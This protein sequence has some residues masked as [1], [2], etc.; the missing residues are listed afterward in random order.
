[1]T[2]PTTP[3]FA[4]INVESQHANIRSE[5][6]SGRTQTRSIGAQ[7][8]KFTAKYNDLTRAEFAPV[9]A[10]I[11]S[12]GSGT[13]AFNITPP[14]ISN[15]R[16]S[17]SGTVTTAAASIGASSVSVSGFSGNIKAGDF[18]KFSNHS[19]VYMATADAN[20]GAALAIAP[21]LL[22]A[23]TS[24]TTVSYN[25]VTFNMRTAKDVQKFGL[26]EFDK[27]TYE[28]DMIEVI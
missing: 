20:S 2:Y 28:V 15:S 14:V 3:E 24:S 9:Y 10:Y 12:K 23:V 7:R 18:I 26:S 16:G 11:L 22:S 25:N 13:T 8:W 17:V 6:R 1:M 5:T 4:A 27:Y 21:A 19:K